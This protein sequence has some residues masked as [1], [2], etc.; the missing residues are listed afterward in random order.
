M[1]ADDAARTPRHVAVIMDGNGRWAAKNHL[2][3]L[4]GHEQGVKAAKAAIQA[5]LDHG[6]EYLTLYAFSVENWKRPALEVSGLMSLLQSTLQH[7]AEEY[8]KQGIRLRVIGRM[9]D[10]PASIQKSLHEVMEKTKHHTRLQLIMALSYGGRAEIVD[11]VRQIGR[12]ISRG[13]IKPEQ[14]D[15]T[16]ISE[17]LYA[18]DIPDPDLLIRTSGEWRLSNFLLWQCSYTELYV[19]SVLWPDFDK[20]E[21]SRAIEDYHR[22]HRRFGAV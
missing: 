5:A 14:I 19:T 3:R 12:R 15:E 21:F 4:K 20:Q 13:E 22:R 17:H 11:A 6:I 1:A 16:T 10:L 2:P 8:L 18:P 9:S 7:Q